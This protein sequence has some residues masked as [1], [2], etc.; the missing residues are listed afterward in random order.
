MNKY[1]ERI[2]NFFREDFGEILGIYHDGE[3][4]FLARL[5]KKFETAE[6]NFEIDFSDKISPVEQLAEKI[7]MICNQRGWKTSK[8]G[9]CLRDD[10]AITFRTNFENVPQNEI[11]SAVKIWANAQA[12]KNSFY[13]FVEEDGEIWSETLSQTVVEEYISVCE[14]NS[15]NLCALSVMP[16][17]SEESTDLTD[18]LDR[19]VF[20]AKVIKENKSP[21]LLA[22]K[23]AAWN[24]KKISLTMAIIFLLIF[25]V[26]AA[27]LFYDYREAE[28]NF[29]V[30]QKI[31]AEKS[32]TVILKKNLDAE[33]EE[34]KKI[35][36]LL[37]SQVEKNPKLNLLIRLGKI[38]G[39]SV[40][41]KKIIASEDSAQLEGTADNPD[42]IGKYLS[43]LKNSVAEKVKLENTSANEDGEINF[44][45]RLTF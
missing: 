17:F 16:N 12:G 11:E 44:A 14:K 13:T 36:S 30:V 18:N 32:E 20:I 8:I 22:K 40:R 39:G 4:I 26:T 9:L 7:L 34:M 38:S 45:I 15:L 6:I 2:K 3:K 37:A 24:L 23:I 35:N 33:V 42:A 5:T 27:K 43:R 21:N 25:F 28:K 41:L 19:A 1:F 29:E 31:L 10:D